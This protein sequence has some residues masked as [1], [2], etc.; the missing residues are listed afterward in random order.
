MPPTSPTPQNVSTL[1]ENIRF[2]RNVDE[3]YFACFN[4]EEEIS[5]APQGRLKT[6]GWKELLQF[7]LKCGGRIVQK[8]CGI[9]I[10]GELRLNPE[11][12]TYYPGQEI[13]FF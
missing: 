7:N 4:V 13:P 2:E 3:A 6:D 11:F 8:L 9:W 1:S 5:S 10:W 12:S